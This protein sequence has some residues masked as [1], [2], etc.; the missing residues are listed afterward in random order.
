MSKFNKNDKIFF[1][2]HWSGTVH[3]GVIEDIVYENNK[4]IYKIHDLTCLGHTQRYEENVYPTEEACQQAIIDK[5]MAIQNKY[6]ASINSVEDLI[7]FMYQ[8]TISTG[9]EEYTDYNARTVARNKAKE[10]LSL[11]LQD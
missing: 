5:D 2:E 10:L 8:H 1:E 11:D 9:A 4:T 7:Q 3:T 6:A